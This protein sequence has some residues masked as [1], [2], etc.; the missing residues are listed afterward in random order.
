MKVP[1]KQNK[2]TV[3]TGYNTIGLE[4][5]ARWEQ[6]AAKALPNKTSPLC[7]WIRLILD[8]EAQRILKNSKSG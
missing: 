5:R 4:R 8:A 1:P 7:T 2:I 3:P 6:A